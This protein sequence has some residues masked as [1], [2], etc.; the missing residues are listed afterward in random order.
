M[1]KGYDNLE[2]KM[3]LKME[4]E[5]QTRRKRKKKKRKSKWTVSAQLA[6]EPVPRWE[7][8]TFARPPPLAT[9]W[10]DAWVPRKV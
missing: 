6:A 5:D 10:S 3:S 9:R 4:A 8:G 1:K 2:E 7:S